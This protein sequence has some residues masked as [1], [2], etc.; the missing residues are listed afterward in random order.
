MLN[1][2]QK[3]L[4]QLAALLLERAGLKITP[5]GYHS[6]RLALSTRMPVAGISDPE[7][8]VQRLR[9]IGGEQELRS[10]LPLVTVGHT[11]FF[12]DPKQFRAL[13]RFILPQLL[14]KARREMRRVCIWSAGCATGEEAYSVAMVMAELGALA[15]EVDLWATDLNLAAVES[16]RLGRF[17]VRRSSG[18][19]SERLERFFHPVED[20][21][22]VQPTLREYVRFEGQNLAAPTFDAVTPGSLDLILCRNVIIY[23]D[24]P[25][26]R[27]LMDRFLVALRPGGL[28]F[29]GYSESLFK[30]Y[31]RFEMIEVDGA[32]VYRRPLLGVARVKTTPVP[33]S[34]LMSPPV[35]TPVPL[36]VSPAGTTPRPAPSFSRLRPPD[37]PMPMS[38]APR[39][40][41]LE[42]A[43]TASLRNGAEP[44][45]PSRLT[46]EV[47]AP[48]PRLVR[49]T[50]VPGGA[51]IFP[52]AERLKQAVRKM[53]QSDFTAAIHDVEK[54]LID[55]PGHL[56]A[57]LTLG[58]LYSLT[59][60]IAE[61]RE[62][63]AQALVREPLCVE[64]RIFG[65]VAALQA[66][67]LV[68]ARSEFGKALFL[69]PTLAL[70]H[71]LLA[72]VQERTQDRDGARRSYRNAIAQL[73]FPQRPL[74][75]HY[76]DI[77]DSADAI[78]RVARYALA[79]LE[80]EGH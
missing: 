49:T 24:L 64:A 10:L 12:R 31:D 80:E 74:A 3:A 33:M 51:K 62:A 26:I 11:E 36:A 60:R 6:L 32:F 50:E 9:D 28:L 75:G 30:V 15:V 63:F 19:S 79:A 4:Q 61:A 25:T 2:S 47:P 46:L 8:Y 78:A 27:A 29:L 1:V 59:G 20:G 35:S 39:S 5:D 70:G 54:L 69:E 52:P 55:E 23:F 48:D 7:V 41:L 38:P 72:Q 44:A 77:P 16:A 68:E 65:G 66:G 43:T 76:P 37:A 71:Y 57:L 14:A 73:R 56:D 67:N 45:R 34:P 22:E 18:I 42:Q 17:S 58:N 13:E 40:S 53:T 21:M